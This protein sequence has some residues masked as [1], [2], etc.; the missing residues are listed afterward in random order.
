MDTAYGSRPRPSEYA[1][2]KV[3]LNS[4]VSNQMPDLERAGVDYLNGHNTLI[5]GGR[6]EGWICGPRSHGAR[7]G[8]AAIRCRT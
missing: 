3:K 6:Y 7:H 5:L 8:C 4:P 2:L 1:G